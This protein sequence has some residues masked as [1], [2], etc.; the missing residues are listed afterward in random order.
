MLATQIPTKFPIPFGNSAAAGTIR[1]VPTAD[2]TSVSPGAASLTT[3]FPVA[4]GQPLASGGV[5]PAMQDFNG[6]FNQITAWIRWQNAGAT[7]SY[8]A[9]FSTAVGGY[10]A[11][12]ILASTTAG[13]LWLST[14][15]NNLTNPDGPNPQSWVKIISQQQLIAGGKTTTFAGAVTGNLANRALTVITFTDGNSSDFTNGN[16]GGIIVGPTG[17]GRYGISLRFNTTTNTTAG[18]YPQPADSVG[19][20]LVNNATK[21]TDKSL[22]T[23]TSDGAWSNYNSVTADS[24]V[25]NPGDVV[26]P[27]AQV[28]TSF[29][30]GA[31]ASGHILTLTKLF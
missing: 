27:C 22:I 5:P 23:I 26:L 31:T 20:I 25:L 8:D 11:G 2:Q 1:Q 15:D 30:N 17:A 7:V 12:A 14:A 18:T 4:T 3:G 28:D 6:L 9:A 24:V 10:P 19:F 21:G 16:T 13:V 29:F